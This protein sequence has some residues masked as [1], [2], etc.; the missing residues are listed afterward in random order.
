MPNT[1][2]TGH[3]A[4]SR[5][6]GGSLNVRDDLPP[7][8]HYIAGAFDAVDNSGPRTD[9]VDPSTE[10][11]IA[12]VPQG[13]AADVD[14]AVAAAVAAKNDWARLVPKDR[15]LLLHRIADRIEQNAEVLARLESANTGKP[16]EVSNDDVAGTVDT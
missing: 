6:P 3:V 16:F 4:V 8:Q 10:Q 2:L 5:A 13:T 7:T 9:V 15:S 11:V 14:R 12:A 1:T